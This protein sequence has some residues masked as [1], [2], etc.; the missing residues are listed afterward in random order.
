[1]HFL[2]N[3]AT[4]H[5]PSHYRDL[6]RDRADMTDVLPWTNNET[7]QWA[8]VLDAAWTGERASTRW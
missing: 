3:R 1:M 4:H 6:K 5:E 2:K 8:T 7:S